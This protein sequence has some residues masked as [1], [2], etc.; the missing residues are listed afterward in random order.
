M[1]L[2]KIWGNHLISLF[3]LESSR[4][5]RFYI[6]GFFLHH[7]MLAIIDTQLSNVIRTN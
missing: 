7:K 2:H 6:S 3:L 5:S 4:K 1:L